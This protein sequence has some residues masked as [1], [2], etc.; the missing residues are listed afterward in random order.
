MFKFLALLLAVSAIALGAPNSKSNRAAGPCDSSACSLPACRCLGTDV[1]GNLDTSEIPQ[2]VLFTFDD[3]I[4]ALNFDNYFA[5]IFFDRTNPDGCVVQA[6]H[7]M[8]HE[9]TD[10]SKVQQLHAHGQEIAL[11]SITHEPYTDYWNN[12]DVEGY[13]AEFGGERELIAHFANIPAED[14]Q[15]VRVPLLQL[16]GDTYFEAFQTADLGYDCSWP[17][18]SYM[19]PPL[20]PYTLDYLSNQDCPIGRCPTESYPGRWVQPMVNWIDIQG[21][22][23][24]MV[25]GCVF[26]PTE[27]SDILEWIKS[28]FNRH[29]LNNKAPFGFYVHAAWFLRNPNNLEAY[30]QF[31]DYLGT[32]NDV[33]IVSVQRAL[34]W[35]KNPQPLSQLSSAW[36]SCPNTYTPTCNARSCPLSKGTETRYMMQCLNSCP[37]VFPWLHNPLGN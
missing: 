9:Y 33:Y 27:T 8:S 32:L 35:V 17:T 23:C 12:L 36:P 30:V 29:Y 22:V 10:Y 34:E 28:N 18:Q 2:L 4:T 26:A 14:I 16:A 37:N 31:L 20:W 11:H 24:S 15:G 7:F 13:I 21:Y 3:A 6:T 19:D 1:P 5:P 25:D